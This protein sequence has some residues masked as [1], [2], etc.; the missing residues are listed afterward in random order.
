MTTVNDKPTQQRQ[1]LPRWAKIT[2][3]LVV[4]FAAIAFV[5]R[6]VNQY[7]VWRELNAIKVE[8]MPT[9]LA[10]LDVWNPLPSHENASHFYTEAMTKYVEPETPICRPGDWTLLP[11]VSDATKEAVA[12]ALAA[13]SEALELIH[14]AVRMKS[15]RFPIVG[16]DPVVN[17]AAHSNTCLG[18]LSWQSM[19]QAWG[20]DYN[21]A[22]DSLVA[23]LNLTRAFGSQP[24]REA[25]WHFQD[26]VSQTCR[27]IRLLLG[28]TEFSDENL[29][30]V[31]T[32]LA[33]L[34]NPGHL[35]PA[36]VAY[37]CA[38]NDFF[39]HDENARKPHFVA[40]P[41]KFWS[42][43]R[44]VYW[45]LDLRSSDHLVYL[46]GARSLVQAASMPFPERLTTF[47]RLVKESQSLPGWFPFAPKL[48]LEPYHTVFDDV[49]A[50]GQLRCA[51]TALAVERYRLV[52][53]TLPRSLDLLVPD[54]LDGVPEDPYEGTP[55]G[56]EKLEPGYRVFTNS[57]DASFAD[58]RMEQ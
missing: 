49:Q 56:Y 5:P 26:A 16:G 27:H 18:L 10:E 13:N 6:W 21:G 57:K 23:M 32:A 15:C 45:G 47:N 30:R 39:M 12:R 36:I 8:G 25:E 52:K 55:L 48:L 1:R 58:F 42:V 7:R 11:P 35:V 37:R 44:C 24:V 40:V 14:K 54:F 20:K 53:G 9:T 34:E 29:V 2:I 4:F 51:R 19:S 33:E 22:A 43:V 17:L 46:K 28:Q 38:A 50:V 3:G 31:S 41:T